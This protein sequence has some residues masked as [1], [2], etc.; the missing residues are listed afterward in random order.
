MEDEQ[1]KIDRTAKDIEKIKSEIAALEYVV[2]HTQL[3]VRRKKDHMV[4]RGIKKLAGIKLFLQEV[5]RSSEEFDN[6][7]E[8]VI[9]MFHTLDSTTKELEEKVRLA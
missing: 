7:I 6:K 3:N 9:D 5:A 1:A 2:Y 8:N 4:Q